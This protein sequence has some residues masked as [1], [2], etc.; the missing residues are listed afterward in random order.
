M[1]KEEHKELYCQ[2]SEKSKRL[3]NMQLIYNNG[4]YGYNIRDYTDES[5]G[6]DVEE[7]TSIL[8]IMKQKLVEANI[9]NEMQHALEDGL[10]AKTKQMCKMY[11]IHPVF[12]AKM[13]LDDCMKEGK[14]DSRFHI[15]DVFCKDIQFS[16]QR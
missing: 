13:V 5:I 16:R 4:L 9:Y 2:L 1:T 14:L 10:F 3:I 6:A 15:I 12:L 11:G 7:M 8:S